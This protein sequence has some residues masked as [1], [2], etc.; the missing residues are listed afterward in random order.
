MAKRRIR[1]VL[2]PRKD[3]EERTQR[4]VDTT[5]NNRNYLA[6]K[7]YDNERPK[8]L[9]KVKALTAENKRLKKDNTDFAR[10]YWELKGSG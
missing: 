1:D 3:G 6:R 9:D 10:M 7:F 4:Q 2:P 8:L 5:V